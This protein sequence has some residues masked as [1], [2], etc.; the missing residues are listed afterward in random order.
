MLAL[1]P[2]L[3][4]D[5]APGGFSSAPDNITS[6]GS[7]IFF[8]AGTAANGTELWKTD[9]T[10]AGTVLVKDINPTGTG[11]AN[12]ST[13][14]QFTNVNGTLFFVATNGT[15]G[16][17]LWKSDGTSGGTVMVQDIRSGANDSYI[18]YLTNVSGTLFFRANNT[19]VNGING[20]ELWKSDGTN[21]GTV[22]VKDINT[23]DIGGVSGS[24]PRFLTNV[25]GTLFFRAGEPTNGIELWKSNGTSAGTVPVTN[26]VAGAGSSYPGQLTNLNGT[27]IFFANDG[28]NNYELWRSDGTAGGTLQV[29]DILV[30]STGSSGTNLTNANGIGYFTANN[31][32]NGSELWRTDGTPTGTVMVRD[33]NV[34]GGVAASSFITDITPVG[35][36]IF[37][38]ATNGNANQGRELWTSDG[39][40]GGT[41][42]VRDINPGG[43]AYST[44]TN[45]SN[46]NGTLFFSADNGTI[47]Q[48][49]WR[50]DGNSLGTM[51][52]QD[53]RPGVNPSLPGKMT[54][55]NGNYYFAALTDTPGRELWRLVDSLS[56]GGQT[57]TINGTINND[58]LVIQFTS[59]T[60]FSVDI[61]GQFSSYS[62]PT[63]TN[64]VF[65]GQAGNDTLQFY[66]HA[67]VNHNAF[68]SEQGFVLGGGGL[69]FNAN[70]TEY[71][72]YFGDVPD[73]ATFVDPAGDDILYQL[74]G[75]SLMF[76]GTVTYYNQA[77]G[78]GTSDAIA[79]VLAGTDVLLVYGTGGNDNYAASPTGSAMTSTNLSLTAT[80][81]DSVYA[82][83]LGG[84][85]T[86]VFTGTSAGENFYGLG[87]YG[88][89]VVTTAN[90]LQYL[91]GF[92]QTTVDGGGGFDGNI[93]YD[94]GGNDTF[95]ATPTSA[96]MSGPGFV[97][98]A[99][100]FE[101][102][103]AIASGGGV[104]TANLDGSNNDDL[105]YGTAFQAALYRNG[106]YI[107]QTYGFRQTNANL[108]SGS[109]NDVAELID[110]VGNDI[111]N[112]TGA[113]AEITYASGNKIR[114]SAFDTVFARNQNG[115][116]NTRNVVNPLTYQLMFDGAWV[117]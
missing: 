88:Y 56:V 1:A 25:N 27:L 66:S 29:R 4:V 8:S 81:F 99:L 23:T 16:R 79:S 34:Q 26:I 72:Y 35:N 17:E 21:G 102:T 44:P 24:I 75:Y 10:S 41:T 95:T 53:I 109:G 33:I 67:S 37:F 78:V 107:I 104:D 106:V 69:S 47:G 116:T 43:V 86:A 11:G 77:I 45:L 6:V 9:G 49:L 3:F 40:S 32:V 18:N 46:V 2:E 70:S 20:T 19:G 112:A 5:V 100:N 87:G 101:S 22:L 60:T 103:N 96:Q 115:G 52:V 55:L 73:S 36:R 61:N 89:S 50:S 113:A 31:G 92:S 76:N 51:L 114:V 59:A 82:F 30:G 85:D 91:I 42:L 63:I 80:R 117:P 90:F 12:P 74:P 98:I 71:K 62:V 105:F 58:S 54:N 83:G 14:T 28:G 65:N 39:T 13:P 64:I 57:L 15:N 38:S 94:A 7:T 84:V 108:S 110:G 97:D 68:L 48:E 93:F 111:L